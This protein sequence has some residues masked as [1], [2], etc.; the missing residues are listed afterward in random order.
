MAALIPEVPCS[1]APSDV[2]E[3]EGR[4]V[5]PGAQYDDTITMYGCRGHHHWVTTEPKLAEERGLRQ[6]STFELR[7]MARRIR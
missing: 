1:G 7:G 5:N 3:I 2:H 4:G 6:R